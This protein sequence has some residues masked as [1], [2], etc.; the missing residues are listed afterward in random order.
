MNV[1]EMTKEDL[2]AQLNQLRTKV[3]EFERLDTCRVEKMRILEEHSS[4]K[5]DNKAYL[6][7]R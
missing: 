4:K 1:R 3:A 6:I 2:I 5:T 7:R